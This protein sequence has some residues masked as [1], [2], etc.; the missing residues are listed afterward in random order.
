M[1][2]NFGDYAGLGRLSS[3][4]CSSNHEWMVR[5]VWMMALLS[6]KTA[7]LL[8]NNVW[9]MG[10]IWLPNL[11]INSLAINQP[12]WVIIGPTG[13]CTTT[14]LPKPSQNWPCDS[15]LEPSIRDC[16]HHWVFSTRKQGTAC[17]MTHLT[18]SCVSSCLMSR[19]HGH[20]TTVYISGH[21]FQ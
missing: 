15:L 3:F 13:Y 19:F 10:C 1:M 17:R 4:S 9:I 8:G 5:A 6:W 18:I 21:Y 12:W 16:G 2:F 7:S 14:L 20:D 11:S